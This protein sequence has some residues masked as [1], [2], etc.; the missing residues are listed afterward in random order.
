MQR[1]FWQSLLAVVA[2]NAA[3]FAALPHLP[4][5]A[6]HRPFAIDWGL[7]VDFWICLAIYGLLSRLKWFRPQ[8]RDGRR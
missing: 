8:S 4:F 3:Y 7:A 5:R 6:R 2:G 1:R